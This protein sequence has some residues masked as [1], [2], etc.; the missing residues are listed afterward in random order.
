MEI[1]GDLELYIK[2]FRGF[3]YLQELNVVIQQQLHL[4]DVMVLLG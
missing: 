1:P 4:A 2:I 3:W